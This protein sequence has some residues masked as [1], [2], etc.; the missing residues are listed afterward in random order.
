MRNVTYYKR[1][2][3]TIKSLKKLAADINPDIVYISGWMDRG[4]LFVAKEFRSKGIPVVTGFDDQWKGT[5]RQRIASLFCPVI[6]QKYFSHAWVAGPYQYEFAK[7]LGFKNNRIIFNLLSCDTNLFNKG[8]EYLELKANNYPESFLYVGNFRSVKGTDILVEAYNKYRLNYQ[9]K[10]KLICIGNGEMHSL[11]EGL[12]GV[13]L[14]DFMNQEDLVQ[15]TKRAGVFVL[16]SRFEKWGVVVHEFTSA[17]M[18]LILSEHVG[19]IPTFFVENYNGISYTNNSPNNLA[20]AMALMANR[21]VAELI[22][23]SNNSHTLSSRINPE[24][25]AASFLSILH[26]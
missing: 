17:A 19:A 15:I 24:M 16:P 26:S 8:M 4:Y 11:L 7:R 6:S 9:G 1:S 13:E 14:L 18:P 3:F 12:P 21:N 2:E 25:S 20:K 22:E 23:M 5:V 10:W